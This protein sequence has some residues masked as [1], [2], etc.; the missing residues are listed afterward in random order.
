[1]L[2]RLRQEDCGCE[3]PSPNKSTENTNGWA[4][5]VEGGV[6]EMVHLSRG[7]RPGQQCSYGHPDKDA[8]VKDQPQSQ[9]HLS[10]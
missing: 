6:T 4:L 1:M 10:P 5:C 7:V 8:D 9:R 3:T 2:K